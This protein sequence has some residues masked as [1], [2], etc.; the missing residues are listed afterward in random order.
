MFHQIYDTFGDKCEILSGI[1]KARR[2]IV[3]AG[4]GKIRWVRRLFSDQIVVNI[5]YREEKKNYCT[6]PDCIL[7]D[8]FE[9]TIREWEAL[10]GTGIWHHSAEDTLKKLQEIGERN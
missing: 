2:G 1:P 9:K 6:G 7:I 10:G 4:E 8:D 5:V 3:T